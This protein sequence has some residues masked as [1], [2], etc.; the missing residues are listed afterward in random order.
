ME[1]INIRFGKRLRELRKEQGLT[2]EA[3]SEASGL[4]YKYIQRLEGKSPSS[5]TLNSLKKLAKAFRISP[6]E[7]IKI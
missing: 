4:D 3:L 1:D 7:L 6:S 2:Q 5:P